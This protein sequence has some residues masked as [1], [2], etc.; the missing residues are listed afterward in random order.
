[1][2]GSMTPPAT[3]RNQATEKQ[4]K[5][6]NNVAAWPENSGGKLPV[7]EIFYSIQGEG[8][9]AGHPALFIRLKYCNLGCAWCD[10]R[11]TWDPK[12]V[13]TGETL[14]PEQIVERAVL[15]IQNVQ[16]N[17]ELVHVVITGGEPMLHQEAL[18][19]LL[20]LLKAEGFAF[21]EIETNGTITPSE[22]MTNLVSWWN[23]SPK[24]SNNGLSPKVNLIREAVWMI[25]ATGKA[26]FKFVVSEKADTDEIVEHYLPLIPRES[27]ILMPEGKTASEQIETMPWLLEECARLGFRFSPRLHILAWDNER[28]R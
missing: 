20:L 10:T 25:A 17:P 18:P 14:A 12:Q 26:D 3:L 27:V 8:R 7:S 13:E 22:P 19:A 5:R 2:P 4:M 16:G 11:F 24:L 9:F 6:P 23:C 1:M 28:G 21:F 15:Q